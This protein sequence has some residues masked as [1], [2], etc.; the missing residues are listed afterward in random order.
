[1]S[2]FVSEERF[3]QGRTALHLSAHPK[4]GGRVFGSKGRVRGS[5]VPRAKRTANG[6]GQGRASASKEG[7][8]RGGQ[9]V[10]HFDCGQP[11]TVQ[12]T[13]KRVAAA[14]PLKPHES[15]RTAAARYCRS[16]I[17]LLSAA[18][19]LRS[20]AALCRLSLVIGSL[21]LSVV[22]CGPTPLTA[23]RQAAMPPTR[24]RRPPTVLCL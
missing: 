9:S 16:P 14:L 17:I 8:G 22:C 4:R 18:P 12:A 23:C 24:C 21:S 10:G 7:D 20:A 5:A 11:L 15:L 1:M 13:R 2:A 3:D 19:R 6:K